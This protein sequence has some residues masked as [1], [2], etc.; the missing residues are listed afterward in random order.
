MHRVPQETTA[1][2]GCEEAAGPQDDD[3]RLNRGFGSTSAT[4]VP[5]GGHSTAFLVLQLLCITHVL[6][7]GLVGGSIPTLSC[8]VQRCLQ[9]VIHTVSTSWAWHAL[10]DLSIRV[11]VFPTFAH[12]VILGGAVIMSRIVY[13]WGL[14]FTQRFTSMLGR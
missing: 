4:A 7:C 10:S 13:P 1:A 14:L 6:C 9:F 3:R 5:H 8:C 12:H 11:H 2:V